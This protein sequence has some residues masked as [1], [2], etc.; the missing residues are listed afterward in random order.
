[1][2][3]FARVAASRGFAVVACHLLTGMYD[4]TRYDWQC[5]MDFTEGRGW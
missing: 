4:I 1:M 5:Y 2:A 3:L